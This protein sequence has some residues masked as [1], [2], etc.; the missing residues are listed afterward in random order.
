MLWTKVELRVLYLS[1]QSISFFFDIDSFWAEE[2]MIFE[3]TLYTISMIDLVT[4]FING[5]EWYKFIRSS[6]KFIESFNKVLKSSNCGSLR[7][8]TELKYEITLNNKSFCLLYQKWVH[9]FLLEH[10][11]DYFSK[12]R[13]SL[14]IACSDQRLP[15][16]FSLVL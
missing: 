13:R 15:K 7:P 2:N 14:C 3:Y 4:L 12:V 5:F 16:N 10:I 1:N 11:W 9:Q 8:I 6:R